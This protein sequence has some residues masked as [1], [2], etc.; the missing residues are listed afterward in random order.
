MP[1]TG[2][3]IYST[4]GTRPRPWPLLHSMPGGRPDAAQR[5]AGFA[6]L[7]LRVDARRRRPQL[8][9]ITRSPAAV[10]GRPHT[11]LQQAS[12]SGARLPDPWSPPRPHEACD[13]CGLPRSVSEKRLLLRQTRQRKGSDSDL[14]AASAQAVA[15]GRGSA[16]VGA[17]VDPDSA[18]GQHGQHADPPRQPL[19]GGRPHRFGQFHRRSNVP[20]TTPGRTGG[21][22]LSGRRERKPGGLLPSPTS[23]L[24]LGTGNRRRRRPVTRRRRL[25][26]PRGFSRL[27]RGAADARKGRQAGDCISA[28]CLP[29]FVMERALSP[30]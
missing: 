21:A 6:W 20:A 24:P 16:L 17:P 29:I 14:R 3:P 1:L 26:L 23:P 22:R 5:S 12:I 7:R 15:G 10:G 13:S 25:P 28:A 8:T 2:P 18:G 11:R 27:R 19:V 4:W 9:T 30:A